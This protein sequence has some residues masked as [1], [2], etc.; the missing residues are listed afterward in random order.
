MF[1]GMT[2][3]LI[4]PLREFFFVLSASIVC[5][6]LSTYSP[7]RILMKKSIPD[8]GRS[9]QWKN[10][11]LLNKLFTLVIPV[12]DRH[13]NLSS[14]VRYYTGR[15]YRKIIYDASVSPYTGDLGDLD[16]FHAGPE[17]QH[18]SYLR[19]YKMVT[20]NFILFVD[21][22]SSFGEKNYFV[23]PEMSGLLPW[24]HTYQ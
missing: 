5:A 22:S 14:I 13:Y 12:R 7:S 1:V 2:T 21:L 8:I 10:T 20:T 18:K 23:W 19:A 15:P 3:P 11:V 4:F 9:L 16:Y 17:F 6:F 24:L